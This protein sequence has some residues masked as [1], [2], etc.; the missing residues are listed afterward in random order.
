VR[1][2]KCLPCLRFFNDLSRYCCYRA[3]YIRGLTIYSFI[4]IRQFP[5]QFF[6]GLEEVLHHFFSRYVARLIGIS[7]VKEALR[8][9]IAPEKSCPE[10]RALDYVSGYGHFHAFSLGRVIRVYILEMPVYA[11]QILERPEQRL[12]IINIFYFTC[13]LQ[14]FRPH[15]VIRDKLPCYSHFRAFDIG[16]VKP[17]VHEPSI[18]RIFKIIH[19]DKEILNIPNNYVPVYD[20][21]LRV[22]FEEKELCPH[23]SGHDLT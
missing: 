2:K 18:E 14:K 15:L 4:V 17:E 7:L 20:L 5:S 9:F 10:V 11:F 22:E 3:I 13:P 21:I 1:G 12:N 16:Y 6:Y 23:S 19:G 8:S